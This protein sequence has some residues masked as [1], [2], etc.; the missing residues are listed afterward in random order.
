MFALVG[1]DA[2]LSRWAVAGC[3][4]CQTHLDVKSAFALRGLADT[5]VAA[6]TFA[7]EVITKSVNHQALASNADA[8]RRS[9]RIE[10]R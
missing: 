2:V 10:V 9:V 5:S 7:V 1:I 4:N 8:A 3:A 6:A